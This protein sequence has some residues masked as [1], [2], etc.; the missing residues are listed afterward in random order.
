MRSAINRAIATG[1]WSGVNPLPTKD[2]TW[3]MV[4]ANNDCVS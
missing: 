4:K 3:K 1:A 2:G